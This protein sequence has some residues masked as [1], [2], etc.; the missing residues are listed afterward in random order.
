MSMR[1][2]I[3]FLVILFSF[4]NSYSQHKYVLKPDAAGYLIVNGGCQ[5]GDT[6]LLDGYFKAV[7]ISNLNGSSTKKILISNVPGK[8]LIIGDSTWNGGAWAHG[9]MFRNCHYIIVA[10]TSKTKFKIIGSKNDPARTAYF[11]FG[12]TE[13]SDNFNVY[14]ISISHGG[15]GIFAKTEVV[16][17]NSK[18]WYPNTLNN[19]SFHSIDITDTYNEGMYIGHTATY[20]NINT[21]APAYPAPSDTYQNDVSTYKQPTILKNV[22]IYNCKVHGVYN[23]AIQTAAINGLK[24]YNNEV[25]DWGK[26]LEYA[27]S[28]GLLIGGRVTNFTAYNY[29]VHDGFGDMLQIFADSGKADIYNNLFVR[30]K[31]EG[32][33]IRTGKGL[34]INFHNNTIAYA[35]NNCIRI[36]GYFGGTGNHIFTKN[37]LLQPT[38]TGLLY[39]KYFFYLENGGRANDIDNIKLPKV[40]DAN[41]NENNYFQPNAGSPV[42][43]YGY[44]RK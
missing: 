30:N 16:A 43:G 20:W 38:F 25:W 8:T 29:Y 17:N 15:V 41:V 37:L 6:I 4:L 19:F 34:I 24:M 39:P 2:A 22:S 26:K 27:N 5:P 42:I 10:G 36:N 18:T 9:L 32:A 11:D 1:I 14:N 3:Y 23:D 31:G 40:S 7:A 35:G 21:N 28:G 12:I 13:S 44:I 33:Q